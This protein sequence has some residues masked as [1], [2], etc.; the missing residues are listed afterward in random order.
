MQRNMNGLLTVKNTVLVTINYQCNFHII[1]GEV[2]LKVL[3]F[4]G[5]LLETAIIAWYC[6]RESFVKEALQ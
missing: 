2:E 6:R 1:A 4:K 5:V 3:K